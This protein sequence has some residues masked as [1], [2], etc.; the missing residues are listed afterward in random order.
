MDFWIILWKVV[1]IATV[2]IY[3]VMAVWVTFQGARDIKSMLA[4][5]NTRHEADKESGSEG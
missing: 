1:F 3:G 2:S 4:D 5:I